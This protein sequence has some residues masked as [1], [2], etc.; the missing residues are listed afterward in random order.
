MG[1][2]EGNKLKKTGKID[3]GL[4]ECLATETSP[5]STK[6]KTL[7]E[8][9]ERYSK[10]KKGTL[11]VVDYINENE[12]DYKPLGRDLC[13]CGNILIFHD[14]YELNETRLANACFC[15]KHLLCVLCAVRRGSK[16]L[17]RYLDR[18]NS[19]I[20]ERPNLKAYMVTF[21][22]KDG[23][24]LGERF[25]HLQTSLQKY[26]KRRNRAKNGKS[27]SGEVLKSEGACWSYEIKKGANSGLWHPHVH[28]VWLCN[29]IPNQ[30][31]L[32]EEWHSITGDSYIVDVREIAQENPAD[33]FLEVFKYAV[34]F[35]DQK[36]EDTFHCYKILKG[37]RLVGSFGDFYGI[38]QPDDLNDDPLEGQP[39]FERMFRFTNQ[40]NYRELNSKKL[41]KEDTNKTIEKENT[42]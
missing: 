6:R 26:H 12:P 40:G 32:S 5:E 1:V 8:R 16:M 4:V 38:P 39:Y 36:P 7:N 11:L 42:L 22:V 13:G 27:C 14:Y 21:T 20:A 30:K 15:K 10:A 24:D 41:H 28:A 17:S 31:K 2:T 18:F 25:K 3:S 34:K 29:S 23:E 33:G 35:S 37:K 19:I 9:L